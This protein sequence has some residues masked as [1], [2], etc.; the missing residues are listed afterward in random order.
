MEFK[1]MRLGKNILFLLLKFCLFGL[2]SYFVL[3]MLYGLYYKVSN[4]YDNYV[5]VRSFENYGI[6]TEAVCIDEKEGYLYEYSVN[7]TTFTLLSDKKYSDSVDK[8]I[9]IYYDILE[10]E[11]AIESSRLEEI[12]SFYSDSMKDLANCYLLFIGSV[13]IFSLLWFLLDKIKYNKNI[14]KDLV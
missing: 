11:N 8:S 10:P 14:W 13:F 4:N 12:D 7:D 6:E 9:K 2:L 1:I 3:I 5:Y